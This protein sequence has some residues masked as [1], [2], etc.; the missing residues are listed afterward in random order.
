MIAQ[1]RK[2]AVYRE[3]YPKIHRYIAGKVGNPQEAEDLVSD[4]FLKVCQHWDTFDESKASVSTWVYTIARNAVIDYYR[5]HRL[6]TELPETLTDD[7]SMEDDLAH[8]ETLTSLASALETLEERQRDIIILRYWKG[9]TLKDI[10]ARMKLSYTYIKV[11]HNDALR[12]LQ[13][14]LAP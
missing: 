1:E 2:E 8:R 10:A 13:R 5:T 12:K 4:V 7:S 3:Y 14:Q 11:L 6:H 9:M